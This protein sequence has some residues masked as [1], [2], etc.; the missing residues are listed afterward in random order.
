VLRPGDK[1]RLAALPD[2]VARLPVESR[3]VF[4]ACVGHVFTIEAI[5]GGLLVLDV[6]ELI[7]PRWVSP[8]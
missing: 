1:V 6:S 2:F 5:E 7:E 8:A 4:A 3:R